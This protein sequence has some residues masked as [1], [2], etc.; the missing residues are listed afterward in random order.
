M[1]TSKGATLAIA[2]MGVALAI[3]T[4]PA[5]AQTA[6]T[7]HAD[8]G[9]TTNSIGACTL[10]LQ[11]RG[12]QIGDNAIQACAQGASGTW[13]GQTLCIAILVSNGVNNA[14]SNE[15]CRRAAL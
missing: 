14:D 13:Y 7:T 10:F 6:S 9:M 15:A 8:G 2:T 1:R 5:V 11:N 12:V 3:G 4:A